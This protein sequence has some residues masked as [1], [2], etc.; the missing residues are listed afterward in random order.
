MENSTCKKDNCHVAVIGCGFTGLAS[1]YELVKSGAKVTIYEKEHNVG[2]LA[3]SFLIDGCKIEKFYHHWFTN[4]KYVMNLIH[5]LS[6]EENIIL[7][8]TNTGMYYANNF[9][10]LSTP[11]DLLKFK[12]LRLCNRFR[13]GLLTLYSR[14]VKDWKK[15]ES[16][17]AEEW[18]K[19]IGGDEVYSVVWE[20]LIRGKFG[21]YASEV[22]AVWIW[23]KLKLRGG[24]RNKR[25]AEELA[26]YRGSFAALA[27]AIA[28]KINK[29][30]GRIV[31]SVSVDSVN[32]VNNHVAGL[33]LSNGEEIKVDNIIS[34]IA[35]PI[36][37][38]LIEPYV[39][40]EYMKI[41]KNINYLAN[42]CLI[43]EL[44]HSLSDIYWLNVNDPS[45]PF[46]GIIEHTNFIPASNFNDKYM[47]YLSKYLTEEDP[48]YKMDKDELLEYSLPFI[49]KMFPYFKEDWIDN[50]YLWH[51]RYAQPIITKN[52]SNYKP[53][54]KTPI[55]GLYISSMA[56]IYPEDRGTNY[57][58]R[59]GQKVSKIILQD[60]K[61]DQ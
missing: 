58:I 32:V 29:F 44:N 18:L 24:S 45:F 21:S 15:L 41:I 25:G 4:D 14:V 46:V 54:Y 52:Y 48:L 10:K 27:E 9:Y 59:E 31:T 17:T 7:R 51:A 11:S 8:P 35:V 12:P 19:K 1:A 53:Q 36:V 38:D 43:L 3:S 30:G 60:M 47:V 39:Q 50:Y 61:Y 13:L 23:N 16:M 49:K 26:Y 5:E 6:L 20:P 2:G 42:V 22:S 57:A 28:E 56:Q 40:K 34:T 33:K 55:K 37:A